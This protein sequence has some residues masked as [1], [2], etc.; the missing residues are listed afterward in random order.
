L[1]HNCSMRAQS[2]AHS[3]SIAMFVPLPDS[4]RHLQSS[5]ES[6]GVRSPQ[7][8][9]D[10]ANVL[11]HHT[12]LAILAVVR[13]RLQSWVG[14]RLLCSVFNTG[15]LTS[16]EV[17]ISGSKKWHVEIQLLQTNHLPTRSA[18]DSWGLKCTQ[19]SFLIPWKLHVWSG[20]WG[21]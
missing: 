13:T 1:L 7:N 17:W 4:Q 9:R 18:A 5:W 15:H 19:V 21:F 20:A 12:F 11:L 8:R 6:L 3:S 2:C 16:S 14:L 10:A